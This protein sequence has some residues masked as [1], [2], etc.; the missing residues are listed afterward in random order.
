MTSPT[1]DFNTK[2]EFLRQLGS[3]PEPTSKVDVINTHMSC[4]FLTDAFVYKLKKPIR[5]SFLDFRSLNARRHFCEESIRLNK[6]LAKDI[7]LSVVALTA[8]PQGSLHIG[9]EGTPVEWLEK[10][11]RV[12]DKLMLDN[13]IRAGSISPDDVRRFTDVLLAF[14]RLAKPIAITKQSYRQRFL[15]N[16]NASL[17][18]LQD[19]VYGLPE[20]QLQRLGVA[21][22]SF[23][24]DRGPL[25]DARVKAK[26][27]IEAHGDLRPEH[28]CL[29]P[30]PVF[31]DCLE[32]DLE[33]RILDSVDELAFLAME[34]E[35]AGA[36]FIGE[37][38]FEVYKASTDDAPPLG[39]IAFYKAHHAIVRAKLSAWHILD[40]PVEEHPK[41]IQQAKNYLDLAE[42][43]T[44]HF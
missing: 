13:A 14:Y 2:V 17:E 21:L 10:M 25:F 33:L 39:L 32:F 34:C 15:R 18:A 1:V 7:Y 16:I 44:S 19:P 26:R 20:K 28:V 4:V 42:A 11:R 37:V 12:P 41:W 24:R 35:R 31:I 22:M 43:Y 9:G 36:G 38:M 23:V 3:Y 6:R 29:L 40:Y 5:L 30:Q 27:I 8:D